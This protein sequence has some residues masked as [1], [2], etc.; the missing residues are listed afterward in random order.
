MIQIKDE[1]P[2]KRLLVKTVDKQK[3][4][5]IL[6][7]CSC[8]NPTYVEFRDS[9]GNVMSTTVVAQDYIIDFDR[10]IET[11]KV[12]EDSDIFGDVVGDIASNIGEVLTN[13]SEVAI[14]IIGGAFGG[15]GASGDQ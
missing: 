1:L 14:D 5:R 8:H 15:G 3:F 6:F 12:L 7:R 11:K 2:P 13:V 4:F 9:W 10:P